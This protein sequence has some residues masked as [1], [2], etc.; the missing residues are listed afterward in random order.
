MHEW[1]AMESASGQTQLTGIIA[2]TSWK[3]ETMSHLRRA[4]FTAAFMGMIAL[5]PHGSA[6]AGQPVD[7]S[8]LN[9]PPPSFEACHAVGNGTT[10]QGSRTLPPYGPDD[11]GLVCG[12]GPTAFDIFDS[13]VESQV[14]RRDYDRNNNLV[15]RFIQETFVS[16]FSNVVAGTAVP[17]KQNNTIVDVLAVPGDFRTATETNTG[18]NNFT[19]P[20]MGAVFLN[21][22]RSVTAPD[23]TIEFLAGPSGFYDY[24]VNQNASAIQ[25]LC[26]ALA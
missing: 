3:R 16:Q 15:R 2:C 14:A 25:E 19:V 11:T 7:P 18:E 12:S 5:V 26:A 23:G 8:T 22:G 10:C 24:F 20:H 17:Y 21:A 9:P 4:L 6:F 1:V 13:G